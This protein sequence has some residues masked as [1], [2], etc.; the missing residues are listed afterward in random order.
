MA[1][2]V[3]SVP[4]FKRRLEHYGLLEFAKK[5]EDNNW[6]TYGDFT[7]AAVQHTGPAIVPV[8]DADFATKVVEP[9]LGDPKH[10]LANRVAR[11]HYESYTA[12]VVEAQSRARTDEASAPIRG[13]PEAER[14]ER[15][16]EIR[17]R[18]APGIDVRH[19]IEPS[20][21]VIDRFQDQRDKENITWLPWE[22]I[23][24][25]DEERRSQAKARYWE[26]DP[27]DGTIREKS[28]DVPVQVTYGTRIIKAEAES[29]ARNKI[30]ATSRL[31]STLRTFV[32][33]ATHASRIC[34]ATWLTT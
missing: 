32:S 7:F 13:L 9:L 16:I 20:N 27:I 11:L 18:L 14:K 28:R 4:T 2:V 3:D 19:Q 8:S 25:R 24:I 34:H 12:T 22:A 30:L 10:K 15:M 17:E 5:F 23:G 21:W 31:A 26:P 33:A 6:M 1:S 29:I